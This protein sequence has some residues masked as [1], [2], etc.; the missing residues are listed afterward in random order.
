MKDLKKERNYPIRNIKVIRVKMNLKKILMITL[1]LIK[2]KKYGI[3]CKRQFEINATGIIV[4]FTSS[5][6][7]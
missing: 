3:P 7:I 2:T 1:K 5:G 4:G 6:C